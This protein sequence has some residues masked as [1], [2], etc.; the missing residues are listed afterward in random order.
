MF[1]FLHITHDAHAVTIYYGEEA[2]ATARF[3]AMI[4]A[5]APGDGIAI[6][7]YGPNGLINYWRNPA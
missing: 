7:L 5:A 4:D 6:Y 3:N 1:T 2:G